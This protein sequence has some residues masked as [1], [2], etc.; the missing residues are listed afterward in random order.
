MIF[1]NSISQVHKKSVRECWTSCCQ[2]PPPV[3]S[4]YVP[5]NFERRDFLKLAAGGLLASAAAAGASAE[6]PG[7]DPFD[8][9]RLLAMARSLAK[10]PYK[11]IPG[12]LIAPFNNLPYDDYVAIRR[13]PDGL[14]WNGEGLGF[15]IEPLHRGFLFGPPMQIHIVEN[16]LS[17]RLVYDQGKYDFGKLVPPPGNADIGFS[18]F[19]VLQPVEGG[20]LAEIAI[21]QGASFYRAQAR[22]QNFG[23]MA[24]ALS[25]RTADPRGEEFPMIRAVWIEKPT[26]A[27]GL[28]VI[29]ALI[30]SESIAGAYRFTLRTGEAAIVDTECTLFAR[31]EVDHFGLGGMTATY[32]FGPID[33]RRSEDLRP[34]VYEV[35]GL[36]MLNGK[37]EW[38][39]RPIANRETLQTSSFLDNN[40]RGFG[41][42]QRDR[43]YSR[44][45]D[46]DQHWERRPS[47]WI[48]P[49]G[50]WGEGMVQL[51]EIPS[52]SEV[53]DNI[54][55]YWRPKNV[56]AAGSETAFAYRQFWCWTPPESSGLASVSESRGGR[57]AGKRRRFVVN[58]TGDI[59]A[60]PQRAGDVKPKISAAPGTIASLRTFMARDSKTVRVMFDIEPA[61]ENYCEIRLILE[62]QGKPLSETWLYRWTP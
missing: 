35:N 61:S 42:L 44:F 1:Q 47:L 15:V 37:G 20:G 7:P 6:V 27:A 24:R 12:D 17:Q 54:I 40:P 16:G 48:E 50:D 2:P 60:D 13:K 36:Q 53:N 19:R 5:L 14:A 21:F 18:G 45:A 57:T 22:N 3:T 8:A 30:D 4:G 56:L 9:D 29:H 32:L 49:I 10:R 43:D 59:L 26:L 41:L 31:T 28:L 52:D 23:T 39:W 25:I 34:G 38:I 58:F 33:R 62:S 46:D 51:L 11:A 55:A